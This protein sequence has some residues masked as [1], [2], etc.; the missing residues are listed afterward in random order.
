MEPCKK[1][2]PNF[3]RALGSRRTVRTYAS[4][5]LRAGRREENRFVGK[6]GVIQKARLSDA[7]KYFRELDGRVSD[8][9]TECASAPVYTVWR[10]LTLDF[11]KIWR[12]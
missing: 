9:H 6:K 3:Y 5:Q 1:L 11:A 4:R 8:S 7:F 12:T 2:A 10:T